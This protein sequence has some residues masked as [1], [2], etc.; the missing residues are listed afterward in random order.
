MKGILD[1]LYETSPVYLFNR[2]SRIVIFS[3]IHKG[4]GGDSDDFRENADIYHSA[5]EH[6]YENGFI[7]ILLGDIEEL[8]EDDLDDVMLRYPGIFEIYE[9]FYTERRLIKIIG[10]HDIFLDDEGY[11]SKMMKRIKKRRAEIS[12]NFPYSP[13]LESLRLVCSEG[14]FFLFHGHQLDVV[15]NTLWKISRFAVRYFWKSVQLILRV[16][17]SSPS[18]VY[19]KRNALEEKYYSWAA[20]REKIVICG[21]T[22]RAMFASRAGKEEGGQKDVSSGIQKPIYFNTGCGIYPDHKITCIELDRGKMSLIALTTEEKGLKKVI[23]D[24]ASVPDI[25]NWDVNSPYSV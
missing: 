16:S 22:H 24:S 12:K 10:N 23:L 20:S 8:W 17:S 21:H 2:E 4:D 7:L 15:S 6:Y 25:L 11:V 9:R 14:E 19:R 13:V 5:L 18:K 3:D 1:R